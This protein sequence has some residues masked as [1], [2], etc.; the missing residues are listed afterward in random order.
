MNREM[1]DMIS[2]MEDMKH[3]K[4]TLTSWLKEEVDYGKE[5]FDTKSCGEVSDIIKDMAEAM[6]ECYEA[7]YYET[8]IE[9]MSEGRDPSYGEG[10]YGYNHRHM[11]NGEFADSGKGHYVRGYYPGPYMNQM[12][13]IDSYLNDPDFRD[14]MGNDNTMKMGYSPNSSNSNS[15]SSSGEIYDNYCDAKR[16]Y[17]NLKSVE[18]REKME[19]HCM[20]YMDNTLKNLRSMWKDADPTLKAKMKKDFKEELSEILEDT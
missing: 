5:C 14:R 8:V 12:P 2:E 9:A 18:N 13:Y 20:M 19:E 15:H 16:H 4:K 7:C 3:I 10:S 6:K 17:Q 1:Q 11:S